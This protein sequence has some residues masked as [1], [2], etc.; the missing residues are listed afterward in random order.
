MRLLAV[1]E[2]RGNRSSV[3]PAPASDIEP[4]NRVSL[5]FWLALVTIMFVQPTIGLAAECAQISAIESY[6]DTGVA[7][8]GSVCQPFRGL[9]N[10]S[11][12]SCYWEFQFRSNEATSY[13][14]DTWAEVV[15]CR[16][17]MSS[18]NDGPVNHPDSYELTELKAGIRVYRVAIKDKGQEKRTLVFLSVEYSN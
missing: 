11:G 3:C 18:P 15:R 8:Y 10:S 7:P 14:D 6:D 4:D 12:V 1:L 2:V 16:D 9:G 13:F 5:D 17:G